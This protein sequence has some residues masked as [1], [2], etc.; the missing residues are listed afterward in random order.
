MKLKPNDL[1]EKI[2]AFN[3]GKCPYCHQELQI[4][5]SF[6]KIVIKTRKGEIKKTKL[7]DFKGKVVRN[8]SITLRAKYSYCK[9]WV[10]PSC[11]TILGFTEYATRFHT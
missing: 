10:C 2:L 1:N 5:D 4:E 6:K 11:D 8:T 7:G 9:M 3:M